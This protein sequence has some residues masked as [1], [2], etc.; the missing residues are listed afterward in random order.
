MT[1]AKSYMILGP[2]HKYKNNEKHSSLLVAIKGLE[3]KPLSPFDGDDVAIQENQHSYF[4]PNKNASFFIL[5]NF[6]GG[7]L[8]LNLNSKL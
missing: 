2:E 3:F 6:F 7:N 8:N 5:G 1:V 4:R